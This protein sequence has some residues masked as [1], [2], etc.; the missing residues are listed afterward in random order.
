MLYFICNGS[1]ELCRTGNKRKIQNKNKCLHLESIQRLLASKPDAL[2]GFVTGRDVLL[3][4]ALLQTNQHATIKRIILIIVRCVLE[5]AVRKSLHFFTNI[6]VICSVFVS[7][8]LCI[9]CRVGMFV[10]RLRQIS[11]LCS[12]LLYTTLCKNTISHN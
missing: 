5:Q 6:V 8:Y 7:F 11:S 4:F 12:L 3:R 1:T 10:I 9:V 2:D